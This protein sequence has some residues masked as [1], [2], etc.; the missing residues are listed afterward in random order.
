MSRCGLVACLVVGWV[1]V[2]R[3]I[4]G[5]LAVGQLVCSLVVDYCLLVD[6]CLIGSVTDSFLDYH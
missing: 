6:V 4:V 3:L 5:L 1:H 2:G